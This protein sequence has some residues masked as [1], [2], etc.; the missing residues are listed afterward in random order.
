MFVLYVCFGSK[1]RPITFGCVAKG[2]GILFIFRSRLFLYSAGSR[3][4]RV[5]F[6]W[7]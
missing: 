2:S 6:V 5:Q 1:V 7:I 4:N 3:V